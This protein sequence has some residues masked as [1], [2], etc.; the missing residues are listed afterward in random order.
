MSTDEKWIA[1]SDRKPQHMCPTPEFIWLYDFRVT[2]PQ[3][4][5]LLWEMR[6]GNPPDSWQWWQPA[7]V[8]APPER[9]LTQTQLD[10]EAL[11]AWRGRH[12]MH[13]DSESWHAALAWERAKR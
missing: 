4:V 11:D 6:V 3:G 7:I 12:G 1:F 13:Y 9:E 2:A 10:E 5:R 8:P